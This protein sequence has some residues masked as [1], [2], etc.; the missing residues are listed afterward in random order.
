MN[1]EL[2]EV[3]PSPRPPSVKM[4]R[5]QRNDRVRQKMANFKAQLQAAA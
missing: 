3:V 1:V 2:I 5:Q 4:S